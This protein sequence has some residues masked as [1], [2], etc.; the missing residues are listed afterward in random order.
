MPN[1]VNVSLVSGVKA[2]FKGLSSALLFNYQGM[3]VKRESA[4]RTM[5]GQAKGK[6][7]VVKNSIATIAFQGTPLESAAKYMAGPVA[8]I[9]GGDDIV[10]VAKSVQKYLD[11][12][13]GEPTPGEMVG[14]VIEGQAL[15]AKAA[16]KVHTMPTKKDAQA[17]IVGLALGPGS[18]I[19][20]ILKAIIEKHEGVGAA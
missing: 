20:G 12:Q 1:I 15:D 18:K 7:L 2:E 14:A 3:G 5:V 17:H 19:A 9:Y 8:I 13:E 10:T 11:E 16:S 6:M 4:L